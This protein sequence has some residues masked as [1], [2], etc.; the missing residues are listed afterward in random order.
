MA[1]A[2]KPFQ[3][4]RPID[5][6]RDRV[7]VWIRRAAMLA[8]TAVMVVALFNVVGQRATIAH[9]NASG[10]AIEVRAPATVRAGLLF[11]ARIAITA[12]DILPNTQLVLSSGWVDGFTINTVEPAPS[13]EDS[14][15]DGSLVFDL[16]ALQPGQTW[17]QYIEYQ[18]NPTSVSRRHQV[19]T[20][21]S[22]THPV[23]SLE[24]TMT[25]VP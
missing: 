4:T 1:D 19:V 16:G 21:L 11:Q 22:N 17:V 3:S 6:R 5:D 12:H 13:T 15:P 20:V 25:V 8:L 7:G 14:G 23:V 2:I 9:A 24:R 10:A 18:V